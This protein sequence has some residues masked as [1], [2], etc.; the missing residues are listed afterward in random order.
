M[1]PYLEQMQ[2]VAKQQG[3][4][5][6]VRVPGSATP[7]QSFMVDSI[8]VNGVGEKEAQLALGKLDLKE[9]G[10]YNLEDLDRGL[11]LLYG[12]KIYDK[13]NFQYKTL[14]NKKT[15]CF[16]LKEKSTR[17]SLRFGVH[18]DD[19]FSIGLLRAITP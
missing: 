7:L 4:S 12:S 14:N 2:E 5:A 18:Y 13:A 1:L 17:H 11:D 9:P 19:D 3:N 10:I 8:L 15:A 16:E 6:E